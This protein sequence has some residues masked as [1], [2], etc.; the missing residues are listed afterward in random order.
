MNQFHLLEGF[1]QYTDP[2]TVGPRH[3]MVWMPLGTRLQRTYRKPDGWWLWIATA[4]V[5]L[6]P[7]WMTEISA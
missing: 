2:A 6:A 7:T 1:A 3:N 4:D 5:V